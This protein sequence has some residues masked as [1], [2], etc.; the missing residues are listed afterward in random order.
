MD[1]FTYDEAFHVLEKIEKKLDS[2]GRD[3]SSELFEEGQQPFAAL[4]LKGKLEDGGTEQFI[5]NPILVAKQVKSFLISHPGVALL[6]FGY[7]ENI[8]S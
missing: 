4:Y 1:Q 8:R 6:V 5:G 3:L 7:N 2:L